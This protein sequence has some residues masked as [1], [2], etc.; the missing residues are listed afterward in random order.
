MTAVF[1]PAIA[2]L[3]RLSYPHKFALITILFALPS[4]SS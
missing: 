2:L 4:L 3:N 1:A